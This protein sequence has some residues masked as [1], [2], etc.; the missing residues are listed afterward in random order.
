MLP[1]WEDALADVFLSYAKE[2]RARAR[3]IAG[4]LESCGWSVFLDRKIAAGQ[5]WRQTVQSELDGAGAV[6]VLWS[7]RRSRAP[8]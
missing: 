4:V 3:L 7:T 2:D 6:V 5:D 8:G 1:T